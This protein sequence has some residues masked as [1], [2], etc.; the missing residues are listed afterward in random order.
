MRIHRIQVS[1]INLGALGQLLRT[2]VSHLANNQ[3][4][5]T[6]EGIAFHNTQLVSQIQLVM[7][8]LIV[9][10]RLGTLVTFDAFTGEDLNIDHGTGN[11]RG[12][13][14]ARVFNIR[15]F[16]TEDGTQ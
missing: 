6:L 10:D 15:G 8:Q 7:T 14:Q 2:T 5:N 1:T 16:F 12:Y 13:A 4:G 9:N 3:S 11:A